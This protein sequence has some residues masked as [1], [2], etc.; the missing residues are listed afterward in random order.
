[1]VALKVSGAELKEWLECSANQFNTIDPTSTEPQSL[2]N[3]EGHPT[4]NFDTIKGIKYK[5]DVTKPSNYNRDCVEQDV[6]GGSQRIV[7]LTYTDGS[8]SLTG[9]EFAT[10]NFIVVTNNYRG[11]GGKFAGTGVDHI[12]ADYAVEN[13]QVLIDYIKE[14][15][16]FDP[17]TGESS[18]EINTA[19]SYNWDFKNIDTSTPLNVHFET[20]DS[21]KAAKFVEQ[22]KRRAMTKLDVEGSIPGFAIYSIDMTSTSSNSK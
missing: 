13:R 2:I 22:N 18:K 17:A 20:Q 7:G 9:E 12:A 10:Q 4:Y 6:K 16:G 3:R 15:S 19:A 14:E 5:I 1:M 8:D 11:F 21:P